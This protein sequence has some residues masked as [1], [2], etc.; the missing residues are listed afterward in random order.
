MLNE[1]SQIDIE[2]YMAFKNR[3][4]VEVRIVVTFGKGTDLGRHE[5]S[6]QGLISGW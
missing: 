6:F 1:I 3:Q 2:V 5:G 4:V